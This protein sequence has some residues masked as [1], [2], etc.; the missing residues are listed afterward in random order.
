MHQGDE[1]RMATIG[2]VPDQERVIYP[3]VGNG[4][5]LFWH[6]YK[7]GGTTI[8]LNFRRL[9]T[10]EFVR[11][12][13]RRSFDNIA[14]PMISQRLARARAYKKPLFVEVHV[15]APDD[16]FPTLLSL[17]QQ[18]REWKA[19][20]AKSGVPFFSF[21]LLRE[22][23][24]FGLSFFNMFHAV[25]KKYDWNPFELLEPTDENLKK[26][27]VWNRQCL[28]L[29]LTGDGI[30]RDKI[31]TAS[32]CRQVKEMLLH[33]LD[34]VGTTEN[35]QTETLPLLTHLLLQN[36][37]VGQSMASFR[38]VVE[39]KRSLSRANITDATK[40]YILDHSSL[41]SELYNAVVDIE[42]RRIWRGAE[43]IA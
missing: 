20:S 23:F 29:G 9:P 10:V 8:R 33:D 39:P 36:V 30:S 6:V 40:R 3:E 25:Q 32:V 24:S 13:T 2:D 38:P 34:W 11:V 42:R 16:A 22:P 15:E 41:D 26:S 17:R 12:K 7:T 5:V 4:V 27:F 28:I 1:R 21:T 14:L 35:L 19:I 18:L 37:S 43:L 31:P